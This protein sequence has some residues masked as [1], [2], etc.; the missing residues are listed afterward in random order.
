MQNKVQFNHMLWHFIVYIMV[1]C[2][3]WENQLI[4]GADSSYNILQM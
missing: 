4:V 3:T 2:S 1:G